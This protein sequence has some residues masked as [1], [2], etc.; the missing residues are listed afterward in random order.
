SAGADGAQPPPRLSVRAQRLVPLHDPDR[1]SEPVLFR[2]RVPHVS[3][4]PAA[5]WRRVANRWLDTNVTRGYGDPR[6]YRA[7]REAI[8]AHVRQTRGVT[9]GADNVIVLDGTRAALALIA[10]V[11]V[12]IGRASC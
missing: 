5:V 3:L 6:G 1:G 4:V 8:A 9:L 7:L 10:D 11:L 12:E 2:P